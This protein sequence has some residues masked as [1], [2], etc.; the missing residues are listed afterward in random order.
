M[1][2]GTNLH[3]RALGCS[4]ASRDIDGSDRYLV[5]RPLAVAGILTALGV[6]RLWNHPVESSSAWG[7]ETECERNVFASQLRLC[8]RTPS[9]PQPNTVAPPERLAIRIDHDPVAVPDP[10]GLMV[11]LREE[12]AAAFATDPRF[13]VASALPP[14]SQ[15]ESWPARPLSG[16]P[17]DRAPI[18]EEWDFLEADLVCHLRIIALAQTTPLWL[19]AELELQRVGGPATTVRM[20]GTWR[21]PAATRPLVP[22][23][24]SRWRPQRNPSEPFDA[25]VVLIATSPQRFARYVAGDAAEAMSRQLRLIDRDQEGA[26]LI[27]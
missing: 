26:L 6:L 2:S 27:E 1:N 9:P 22:T 25:D 16:A 18:V 3:R 19:T 10:V 7:A 11:P 14:P 23:R 15:Y 17:L 21:A 12:L 8:R 4:T 24:R 13:I 20:Q 5:L